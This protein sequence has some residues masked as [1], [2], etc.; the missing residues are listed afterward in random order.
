MNL[1]CKIRQKSDI[2]EHVAQQI[3]NFIYYLQVEK[4]ASQHTVN[5]Y[6]ADLEIFVSFAEEQGAGEV[7]FTQVT[8]LLVRSYMARLKDCSYSRATITRRIAALRSFFRFLCNQNIIQQN[9]CKAVHTPKLA[10]RLPVF[11]DETEIADILDLPARDELGLRDLALL[12]V[13]YA[14]GIRVSELTG[15]TI[16]SIDFSNN[17]ALVYG[18]GRK[19]RIVPMGRKAS[20]ALECYLRLSRPKL[21]SKY[22]GSPHCRL[23]VNSRGGP[24]TDRSVRRVLDKYVN[25][26]ASTK[27]ISPHTIRHT[28]ATHLLNNGADLRSVQEMLGH[29]N[30]STTQ[31]YTHISRERMKSIYKNAHPRA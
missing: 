5:N 2:M 31:I 26:L 4:N 30:L 14:T 23:F 21:Y 24:L 11:L 10:K 20:E 9:P 16:A 6:R 8:P 12:E 13:L 28:F 1:V 18:K 17:C 25:M 27:N 3:D 29:A 19:E 7:L 22:E 15:L